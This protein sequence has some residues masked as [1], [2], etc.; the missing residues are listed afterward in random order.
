MKGSKPANLFE[1]RALI[2]ANLF[3]IANKLQVISDQYLTPSGLT[4]KQWFLIAAIQQFDTPPTLSEVSE[5]SGS[6]RQNVKQLAIKLEKNDFLRIEK[7]AQDT[8]AVRL[9]LTEKCRSF[10]ERREMQDTQFIT[11]LFS[12]LGETETG[13]LSESVQKILK[14]V[15]EIVIH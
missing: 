6:S 15:E 9:I 3:L 11:E 10:W 13:I 4:A 2:F 5:L 1:K 7:D 12:C 14:R 8:R